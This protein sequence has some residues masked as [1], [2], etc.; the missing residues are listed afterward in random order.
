MG[1]YAITQ[2]VHLLGP[3][4]QVTAIG[5][6][7][8]TRR[9]VSSIGR[10]GECITLEVPTTI[11]GALRFASGA[12]VSLASSWDVQAHR[13]PPIE[14]YGTK[15]TLAG[16]DPNQFAGLN[17]ICADG[18]SWEANGTEAANS[19]MA[20]YVLARAVAGLMAGT[21]PIT[22]G[23]VDPETPLRLGD[24]REL[25][26]L[27]M[28]AGIDQ[29]RPPRASGE[30]AYHVLETLLGLQ[31]SCAS[32]ASVDIHPRPARPTPVNHQPS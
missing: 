24:L 2:L 25:G 18:N 22:G 19:R 17:S 7:P 8:R 4:A 15:G 1:P 28:A 6:T 27:D 32:G 21:D 30:L 10:E 16:P 31:H 29:G 13:R 9:E 12:V 26:V 20:P 3:V 14:L 5:S 11:A 23:S